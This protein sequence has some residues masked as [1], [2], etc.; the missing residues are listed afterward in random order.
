MKLLV[1]IGNSRIKWA[2]QY[3]V[4]L[5]SCEAS[6]FNKNDP[7]QALRQSWHVL[8]TPAQVII[9]NVA[10]QSVANKLSAFVDSLWAIAPTFLAVSREAAGVVNGYDDIGQLGVDRWLA[11]ISAWNRY[12]SAVCV[13]D[14][15]TALTLDV[16]TVS[17]RHVGGF[18]VPGLSLMS[19][20]LN[21]QTEQI[22]GPP[23]Y[24][25]SLEPGRNTRDCI[26][27]G[28]WM[29]I[30]AFITNVFDNVMRAHGKDSRCII[31][32]GNARDIKILL[33]ADVDYEPNLV[34][35]GI[36]LMSKNIG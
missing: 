31:T 4:S 13:V 14:C 26:S 24:M 11:M 8:P 27:H 12:K 9:S 22:N 34:L 3:G 16:V 19:D 29:A 33:E 32:G 36:A 18:I 7:V 35:N 1:D 23:G 10:G 6:P 15:G 20:A 5:K 2:Q 17:G 28:A 25:P 30:T 21:H